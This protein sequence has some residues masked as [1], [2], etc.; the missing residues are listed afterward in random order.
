VEYVVYL[1]VALALG[2]SLC[3]ASGDHWRTQWR[4]PA[5][6]SELMAYD[7]APLLMNAAYFALAAAAGLVTTGAAVHWGVSVAAATNVQVSDERR[8]MHD[9]VCDT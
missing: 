3:I 1:F 9:A 6:G 7:T 5:A 4:S 8:I 2:M